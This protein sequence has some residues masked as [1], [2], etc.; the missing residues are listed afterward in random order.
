MDR[1]GTGKPW[2][3]GNTE[4]SLLQCGKLLIFHG[5]PTLRKYKA[6]WMDFELSTES[7]VLPAHRRANHVLRLAS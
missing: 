5:T 1:A 7:W 4:L 3:R 6:Q 2:L